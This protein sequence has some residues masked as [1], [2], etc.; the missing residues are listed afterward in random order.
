MKKCP[1]SQY[2]GGCQYQGITYQKQLEM[3]QNYADRLLSGFHAVEK[4]IPCRESEHYRNKIQISFGYDE[5]RRIICGYYAPNSHFIV[6]IQECMIANEK[7]NKLI[8]SLKRI[9]IRNHI[10]IY[11]ERSRKGCLRHILIRTSNLNESMVVFVT[12]SRT[13]QKQDILVR[14]TLRYNPEVKT[15]VHNINDVPVSKVLGKKEYVLY[16]KGYI[17]DVLNGLSFRISASSFYQVNSYQTEVLYAKAIELAGLT[18]KD[19]LI[20]AYCGTGT[21]GLFASSSVKKVMGVEVNASALKDAK[22][23]CRINDINNA[24]FILDDAGKYMEFLAENQV[25]IDAVIMD[26]PRS[27][28]D[29]RFMSSMVKLSPERIV[30]VSCNPE[31]LKRDLQYLK[32]YYRIE[33]IQP[34]DMFPYTKHIETVCCLYHQ[35]KDFISVPYEPKDADYLK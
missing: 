20:D 24:E 26:P 14:E 35:K 28:S 29:T 15:I 16:G 2:C 18:D 5:Q 4:I 30:Y 17:T 12:G 21:I 1:V 19:T 8:V 11:D 6:P 32:R 3:K 22:T 9:I 33:K 23:N 27:G 7:I 34:V 13:L 31:T 25:H 10:S